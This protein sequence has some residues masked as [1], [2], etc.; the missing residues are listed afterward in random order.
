MAIAQKM[1]LIIFGMMIVCDMHAAAARRPLKITTITQAEENKLYSNLQEL[2]K[3]S[4]R[5][6][7]NTP[8]AEQTQPKRLSLTLPAPDQTNKAELP[9]TNTAK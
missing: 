4:E 5:T 1:I 6:P 3:A 9:L 2:A 8:L 7:A